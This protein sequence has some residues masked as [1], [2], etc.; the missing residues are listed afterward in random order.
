MIGLQVGTSSVGSYHLA[1]ISSSL[2]GAMES[3]GCRYLEFVEVI[4]GVHRSW[5]R[6]RVVR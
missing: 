4:G 1:N 3:R 2:L 5:L 6:G